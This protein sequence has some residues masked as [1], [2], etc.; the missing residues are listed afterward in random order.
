MSNTTPTVML[1]PAGTDT[2][3]VLHVAGEEIFPNANGEFKVDSQHIGQLLAYGWR[4][5]STDPSP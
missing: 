4:I 1:P 5:K 3:T 2:P